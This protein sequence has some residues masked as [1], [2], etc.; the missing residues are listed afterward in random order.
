VA[1]PRALAALLLI[2]ALGA[3]APGGAQAR[4]AP[5]VRQAELW[6]ATAPAP[7]VWVELKLVLDNPVAL[8]AER[9]V[10]RLPAALMEDFTLRDAEPP[11]LDPPVRE[12]DGRYAFV[13]PAPLDRSLNWYRLFLTA[14]RPAPRPLQVA[15]AIERAPGAPAPRLDVPA[16]TPRTRYVDREADPFWVVPE[17]L[18]AWLPSH[19][20]ALLPLLTVAAAILAI[21]AAAGCLAAFWLQKR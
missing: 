1:A 17:E 16:V 5:T 13:F 7:G 8:E 14:R 10:L 6:Y 4:P 3:C 18:V 12:P 2:A 19:P 15:V 20:G 21:T 11:L 9:T